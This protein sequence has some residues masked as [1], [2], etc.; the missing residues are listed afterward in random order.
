MVHGFSCEASTLP[1]GCCARAL[2][3]TCRTQGVYGWRV[4]PTV[5][6]YQSYERGE[7]PPEP[8]PFQ[9]EPLD[10]ARAKAELAQLGMRVQ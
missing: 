6:A 4:H 8:E 7:P 10:A 5:K 3:V 9:P 1:H 2:T